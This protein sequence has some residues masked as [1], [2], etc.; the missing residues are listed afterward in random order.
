MLK[1]I[2][3]TARLMASALATRRTM[4]LAEPAQ[5][6]GY[7][8]TLERV[9]VRAH[10]ISADRGVRKMASRLKAALH[11]LLMGA[12]VAAGLMLATAAQARYTA[13]DSSGGLPKNFYF[14]GYCAT[15]SRGS[16]GDEC[17][18]F[19]TLPY[20]IEFSSGKTDRFR[21][22]DNG[23]LQ[24][25]AGDL[26][27]PPDG[28]NTGFFGRPFEDTPEFKKLQDYWRSSFKIL[29]SIDTGFSGEGFFPPQI[30]ST[31]KDPYY[32]GSDTRDNANS[33]F[34][35]DANYN[36]IDPVIHVA[37]FSCSSSNF[38]CPK[39]LHTLTLTPAAR[40]FNVAFGGLN[41]AKAGY[42]LL[43]KFDPERISAAPEPGV[44]GLLVAG[45]AGVGSA[46][47]SRRKVPLTAV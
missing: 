13:V 10:A 2:R 11:A 20:S 45:F 14:G 4:W 5:A 17:G 46:L 30:A 9:V 34:P 40:G 7:D 19:Y 24:F 39:N 25:V 37:W 8:V 1:R 41:S 15:F 16:I 6:G 47:R 42:T 28:V 18:S 27:P 32:L 26:I 3:H 43:A 44:W 29:E 22:L 31:L 33:F 36:H 35:F 12:T 21:I 23:V 38:D